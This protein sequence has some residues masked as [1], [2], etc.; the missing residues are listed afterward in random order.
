MKENNNGGILFHLSGKTGFNADLARGQS[1]P[2]YCEGVSI[3]KGGFFGE[4]AFRCEGSKLRF[5]YLAPGNIYAARGTICFAFR[6]VIPVGKTPFPV[7]RV[8]FS[9]HTSWDAVFL[10][11]DY[12]GAGF[13]AFVTDNGLSRIRVSTRSM[14]IPNTQWTHI[15]FSWDELYG[16][17]L[18]V[19]GR[20]EAQKNTVSH[21][22]CGLDQF[23]PYSRLISHWNVQSM[24]NYIRGGDLDELWIYDHMITDEE[25]HTTY[26]GKTH[27]VDKYSVANVIPFTLNALSRFGWNVPEYLPPVLQN[28]F[29]YVK[30]VEIHDAFDG[31]KWFWKACDGIEE[32]TW[33]GVYNR[34]SLQGRY[35]YFLL[36]DWDCYSV[37]GQSIQFNIPDEK[38]NHLEFRGAAYGQIYLNEKPLLRKEKSINRLSYEF[39]FIRSGG[40]MRFVNDVQETPI[41]TF[42][43][44]Y[45]TDDLQEGQTEF[46]EYSFGSE[47][48][49]KAITS[50]ATSWL[51]KRYPEYG[52][53]VYV[54]GTRLIE[55]ES[56]QIHFMH[57][58]IPADCIKKEAIEAVEIIFPEKSFQ[59][60]LSDV[61][62]CN[63][64]IHDPSWPDRALLDYSFSLPCNEQRTLYFRHRRRVLRPQ[65]DL[66]ISIVAFGYGK[67]SD[68]IKDL[69]IRV[70]YSTVEMAKSEH[71]E[72]RF[73]QV[74]DVYSHMVEERPGNERLRLFRR[75]K[76]DIYDLL[77]VEPEHFLA[78]CYLYD[79]LTTCNAEL[80]GVRKPQYTQKP[81]VPEIPAWVQRQIEYMGYIHR[82]IEWWI[83]VRQIDN[84][85][86]GGG[87]SDDGDLTSWWPGPALC[88]ILTKKITASLKREMEAFL[89]QG[90]LTNGLSTIQTDEMHVFEEGITCLGQNLLVDGDNP[91][92]LEL[93]MENAEGIIR[94]SDYNSAGHR[95]FK[96]AF[97][98]GTLMAREDPWQTSTGN[99]YLVCHPMYMLARHTRNPA[100][101]KL[102]VEL[103]D[104]ILAH[105]RNGNVYID[106]RF[107][108]DRDSL[109]DSER[110]YWALVAA[111]KLT[112]DT[113]Y[114]EPI[115][116]KVVINKTADIVENDEDIARIYEKH[117][118]DA[119]LREYL[120]TE[121][122]L[123][124]DRVVIDI[125]RLQCDRLGNVAHQRFEVYPRHFISWDFHQD[126][127]GEKVAILTPVANKEQ[128]S[129]RAWNTSDSIVSADIICGEI[130]SG[131]WEVLQGSE[132][133]EVE[134]NLGTRIPVNL[135]PGEETRIILKCKAAQ[136]CKN[137]C[138][139]LGIN[140][141][142]VK[143]ETNGIRV[144][145]HSI[146]GCSSKPCRV[147][148]LDNKNKIV[149]EC[150]LPSLREPEFLLP[151]HYDVILPCPPRTVLQ[152]WRIVID[153]D[154]LNHEVT[155]EN[156]T[157][158]F[159]EE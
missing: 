113:K 50:N 116:D 152:G 155:R 70:H 147:V 37:S 9:D 77:R 137:V 23:G 43:L 71:V 14:S 131:L 16:I 148:L 121:A 29:T 91:R 46:L 41:N 127:L 111:Y 4:N 1:S 47:L 151:V 61:V 13:D 75:F 136:E 115:K 93:A 19:N 76:T 156:N 140:D 17:K 21:L 8:G 119:A 24:F 31:P 99:S 129:I 2:N 22:D 81:L 135:E 6:P 103:A 64:R 58:A 36:P 62:P 26:C 48:N 18:Y 141:D 132:C 125:E 133:Y 117:I 42:D 87:L 56:K 128:I 66:L 157:Y 38:W 96:S 98:S 32:T 107:D 154:G 97:F 102:V 60:V 149:S 89:Q 10:R 110:W 139:D 90:M 52:A 92:W 122:H 86:F 143:V 108:D 44:F 124:V 33:P 11:I 123:W 20:I 67:E 95:H 7:F 3:I 34:S 100:L 114:L 45:V 112:D 69:K 30:K 120:N 53:S 12:N 73:I 80:T 27:D 153:P 105:Y 159:K 84:G 40:K 144:T 49:E 54:A 130:E 28:R 74:K 25:V 35:D 15:A 134:L 150:P 142:D 83:D 94:L 68:L 146:G 78:Q 145:V 51:K 138:P 104:G 106:I 158:L 57:F 101:I 55:S 79:S 109:G 85:E 63:V 65:D 88:G 126:G 72:D 59:A 39:P 5:S 82:F 118:E